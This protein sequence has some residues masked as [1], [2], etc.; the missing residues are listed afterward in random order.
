MTFRLTAI[1]LAFILAPVAIGQT[2]RKR[3][4]PGDQIKVQVLDVYRR[5]NEASLRNDIEESDRLMADDFVALGPSG[6]LIGDKSSILSLMK[7]GRMKIRYNRDIALR[8][9]VDGDR[10]TITGKAILGQELNGHFVKLRYKFSDVYERRKGQWQVVLSR[11]IRFI[12]N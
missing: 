6:K 9:R 2:R 10:A 7:S 12:P 4:D 11:L 1:A 3:A 8:V 5:L